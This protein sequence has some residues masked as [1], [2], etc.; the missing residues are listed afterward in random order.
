MSEIDDWDVPG[1]YDDEWLSLTKLLLSVIWEEGGTDI[2]RLPVTPFNTVINPDVT[3]WWPGAGEFLQPP[4]GRAFMDFSPLAFLGLTVTV[5]FGEGGWNSWLVT[6]KI[7]G[8]TWA[9]EERGSP[10]H[11]KE[12]SRWRAWEPK[13]GKESVQG[14]QS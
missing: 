1:L 11:A 6:L 12:R 8:A 14:N 7:P 9:R 5:V 4:R 13:V 2:S 10:P 3:N